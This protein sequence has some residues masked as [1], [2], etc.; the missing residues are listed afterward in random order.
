MNDFR[1]SNPLAEAA[2]KVMDE[3]AR[4]RIVESKV[5]ADMGVF[6]R[7]AVPSERLPEYDRRLREASKP[8]ATNLTEARDT[9]DDADDKKNSLRR[10]IDHDVKKP[11]GEYYIEKENGDWHIFHTDK[12]NGKAL[13][14]H[15]TK[16]QAD[17]HL[18]NIQASLKESTAKEISK[19]LEAKDDFK[20]KSIKVQAAD[21]EYGVDTERKM[22]KAKKNVYESIVAK[23][24][25]ETSSEENHYNAMKALISKVKMKDAI[26]N[27]KPELADHL[28]KRRENSLAAIKEDADSIMAEIAHNL[29]PDVIAESEFGTAFKTARQQGKTEFEF[30]GKKFNTLQKGEDPAKHAADMAAQTKR[31]ADIA[32]QGAPKPMPAPGTAPKDAGIG[33]APVTAAD[34]RRE[35]MRPNPTPPSS[36]GVGQGANKPTAP[37]PT[38]PSTGGIAAGASNPPAPSSIPSGANRVDVNA[39]VSAAAQPTLSPDLAAKFMKTSPIKESTKKPYRTMTSLVESIQ[40]KEYLG[41]DKKD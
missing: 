31:A 32:K 10:G 28:K 16:Q 1:K 36:A 4:L 35:Q 27:G 25:K 20:K 18:S 13:S 40:N 19:K 38:P 33:A 21:K 34:T 9:S 26:K 41:E 3:N 11:K 30:N 5:N 22:G 15:A 6:S 23:H 17:A 24:L 7:Q 14:T 29:G 8:G 12:G 37:T 39:A 2:K